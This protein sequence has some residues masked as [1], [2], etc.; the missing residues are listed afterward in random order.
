MKIIKNAILCGAGLLAGFLWWGAADAAGTGT[1]QNP[2]AA[3]TEYVFVPG[4]ADEALPYGR[5]E[6]Y[7]MASRAFFGEAAATK[8]V[9]VVHK[10]QK[11]ARVTFALTLRGE[12]P[13][14][15]D[16]PSMSEQLQAV[17]GPMLPHIAETVRL[18]NQTVQPLSGMQSLLLDIYD[19]DKGKMPGQGRIHIMFYTDRSGYDAAESMK[20]VLDSARYYT[21]QAEQKHDETHPA[22]N[23]HLVY[24]VRFTPDSD[25]QV[26][27]SFFINERNEIEL[28]VCY[29]PYSAPAETQARL[30]DECLLRSMGIPDAITERARG[31]VP[32]KSLLAYWNHGPDDNLYARSVDPE[33]A[34]AMP[35][36]LLMLK[37]LYQRDVVPGMTRPQ[38]ERLFKETAAAERAP[39]AR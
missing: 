4:L 29:I 36:D 38:F 32:P 12:N 9:A 3:R 19:Y 27:G 21:G 39:A 15:R 1:V 8:D 34:G 37:I 23:M 13:F 11:P 20:T 7:D 2:A 5:T 16:V 14:M 10:W 25:R 33:L 24:P 18:I 30:I 6:V 17:I 22:F 31:G 26:D 35:L 28:A